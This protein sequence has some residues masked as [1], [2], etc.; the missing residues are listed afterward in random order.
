MTTSIFHIVVIA[1]IFTATDNPAHGQQINVSE[2]IAVTTRPSRDSIT[3]RWAPLKYHVWRYGNEWGYTVERYV[4]AREGV[5]LDQPEKRVLITALKALPEEQWAGVVQHTR[6]G[7]IAAQALYGDRFEIDLQQSDMFTIANKVQENEQRFYFALFS[8]DMSAAV[9]RASGLLFTDTTV[10]ANEKYL[11]RIQITGTDSLRG[12]AFITPLEPY[13]L[14]PPQNPKIEFN[15]KLVSLRWD[16]AVSSPYTAYKVERSQN[17]TTFLRILESPV[18]TLSPDESRNTQYEYASDSIPVLSKVYYYR[19]TGITPFGEEGPSSAVVSGRSMPIVEQVPYIVSA[20]SV[21]NRTVVLRWDFPDKDTLAI[22]GFTVERAS[23]PSGEYS[24]LTQDLLA[25]TTRVYEDNTPDHAN[26]YQVNAIGHD[27]ERYSSHVYFSQLVD[28]IPPVAPSEIEATV[29]DQGVISISWAP[30]PEKDIYGYR[31][32]K[33]NHPN[34]EVVQM[35]SDPL[36]TPAFLDTV[37]LNVLDESVYYSVMAIDGTQNH[38]KLSELLEVKLPDKVK[39]QPPVLLPVSSSD[40]G[41]TLTWLP[42]GSQDV[43]DYR[44]Y[45][46]SNDDRWMLLKVVS[47]GADSLIRFVDEQSHP[48][49][50]YSYVVI[51]VDDAGLE[52][53]PSHPVQGAFKVNSLKAPVQWKKAQLTSEENEVHLSWTYNFANV[54]AFTIFR[55]DGSLPFILHKTVTANI[56]SYRDY[57][58]PGRSYRYRILATFTDGSKSALSDE[59]LFDY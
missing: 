6:Y 3:L 11:Y 1:A 52:S 58:I 14:P 12:S 2:S 27:H 10:V 29:S 53:E 15:D 43:V 21:N 19:I 28:S 47:A 26:Y 40:N 45:R 33:A 59:L 9:A 16:R 42:S 24:L 50:A 18:T 4:I 56:R 41:V 44:V 51:S 8:A 37:D 32:F 13:W 5:L 39:P 7:A 57:I 54:D 48:P 20:E 38:S 31:V 36:V 35:T 49:F 23:S 55:S 22:K 25:A 30:N 34:E 17:G 46:K